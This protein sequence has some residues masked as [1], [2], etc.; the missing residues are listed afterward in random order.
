[1]RVEA[2]SFYGLKENLLD[3]IVIPHTVKAIGNAAFFASGVK[4]YTFES[5][6]APV[7][8]TTYCADVD[9]AIKTL[10][11]VS[12]VA[13]YRGYYYSNFQTYI[14]NYTHY[15]GKKSNLIINYPTN[16]KGYDTY[17]Y[18]V[19]FAT[20]K[21]MGVMMTDDTRACLE[22]INALTSA[23]EV[24]TWL[25]WDPNDAE[26]K[27]QVE[28]FSK[29]V[30][31]ARVHYNNILKNEEQAKI[32]GEENGKKL[33]AIEEKLRAVKEHFN[34]PVYVTAIATAETSAH[35]ETYTEGEIFDW[36]GLVITVTYDDGSTMTLTPESGLLTL[37]EE[38][39]ALTP[40]DSYVLVEYT[41]NGKTTSAYVV[42]TVN[43]RK[44]SL[45]EK[46][47]EEASLMRN[48]LIYGGA[49]MVLV[50][51]LG[52]LLMMKKN[53]HRLAKAFAATTDVEELQE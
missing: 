26:R 52:V 20:K 11:N 45:I 50:G 21:K 32:F 12:N 15:V 1:M 37:K 14:Y 3:Q 39:I 51:G 29:Q 10:A 34:I 18:R 13:L 42:I 25:D 24:A 4:E 16:G 35:K 38:G 48:V 41:E 5:I 46:Y 44:L 33:I 8:E 27:K 17:I 47:P 23:E 28:A 49:A 30:K 40:Y 31:E 36:N 6:Q 43:E 9:A 7:L 53:K 19:Y 22:R 2:Y